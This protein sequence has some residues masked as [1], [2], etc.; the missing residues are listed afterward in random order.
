MPRKTL[1]HF[2]YPQI[3]RK[4]RNLRFEIAHS[5]PAIFE[6]DKSKSSFFS[7]QKSA[8]AVGSRK[9]TLAILQQIKKVKTEHVAWLTH[10]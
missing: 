3:L 8:F 5:N 9:K 6:L 7:S 2:F 10:R 4:S 1:I